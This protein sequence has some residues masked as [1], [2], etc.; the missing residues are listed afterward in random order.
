MIHWQN[1]YGKKLVYHK[2]WQHWKSRTT[3][4]IHFLYITV[5]MGKKY[6]NSIHHFQFYFLDNKI[7]DWIKQAKFKQQKLQKTVCLKSQSIGYV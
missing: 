1:M 3:D 6:F 5:F 2:H 4:R 7:T